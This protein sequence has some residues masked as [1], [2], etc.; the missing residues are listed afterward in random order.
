MNWKSF[1]FGAAAG[2]LGSIAVRE[3]IAQKSTI[4]P[5]KVLT[6]VKNQFKQ[7]GAISGSWIHMKPEPYQKEHI[8]YQVFKGGI[9]KN[10]SGENEQYEFIADA[11]TGTIIDVHSLSTN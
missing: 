8:H 9:S 3:L 4:S 1:L 11:K 6:N 7:N 2:A 10:N 5:E